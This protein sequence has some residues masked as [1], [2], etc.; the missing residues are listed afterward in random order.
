L[1]SIEDRNNINFSNV[2]ISTPEKYISM[3][4]I[5]PNLD[6]NFSIII[7][8]E[9]HLLD[10]SS[11]GLEY[12]L[13][14]SR[15]LL[16]KNKKRFVFM[17]AIIPNLTEIND[18]LGGS[19]ASII[20]SS[21]RPTKLDFAFLEK[22]DNTQYYKLN[23]NPGKQTSF[24]LN[25][26]LGLHELSLNYNNVKYKI[27]SKKGITAAVALKAVKQGPVLVFTPHKGGK[28]GVEGIVEETIK[29][30]SFLNNNS[31]LDNTDENI[32]IDLINYLNII[33]GDNYLLINAIRN[34]ILYH[35]GD[36]PQFIREII[37]DLINEE[38]FKLII[39]TNTLTEGINL[40]IKT[41][42]VNSTKRY[43]PNIQGNYERLNS[44]ELKN[45]VGRAGRA[46]KETKGLII[47]PHQDDFL[48]IMN[49]MNENDDDRLYGNLYNRIIRPITRILID[50]KIVLD[51]HILALFEE[52]YPDIIDSI[53][54]SL[55]ELLSEEVGSQ[56]LITIV[57]NLITST[58]S[59]YQSDED[60]KDTLTK[61]FIHRATA[62][63]PYINTNAFNEIK[64]SGSSISTYKMIIELF[65]F[66]NELWY[67]TD[68]ALSED[69]LMYLLD[70]GVFNMD[71][72]KQRLE[73][74][75]K[76]NKVNIEHN[77]IKA[78]LIQWM[79][80]AWYYELSI[81]SELSVNVVLDLIN[82]ILQYELQSILSSI[83]R[84]AEI[85]NKDKLISPI[86]L[87]WTKM[88]QYGFNSQLKL[89]ILELG[90]NDRI[91]NIFLENYC[92]S[93]GYSHQS[94]D[95]LRQYLITIIPLIYKTT[96]LQIPNMSYNNLIN[97]LN[98]I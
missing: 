14:L 29:Q 11:R 1:P 68:D 50:K 88:L 15:L 93:R 95:G 24:I 76:K 84:I 9:G 74:F 44:R 22:M 80:G 85:K 10:D 82:T 17:S 5:L 59:F 36:F 28:T 83:I 4:N 20:K 89:D 39:C 69:W 57:T 75:N 90:L 70:D 71:F 26:Y 16:N 66:D 25:K 3:Q 78:L 51:D 38:N 63:I 52:E 81:T 23:F 54:I 92:I 35:H 58:F 18:W 94:K 2:L 12:E 49:V 32:I 65:D 91:A 97:F 43:N 48:S 62:L 53:D 79:K 67:S 87:N 34:G 56:E 7:C 6:D 77:V 40:P 8:D 60:E 96:S 46:G 64:G 41:I 37:E 72:F 30:L 61:I 98:N 31:L 47:V 86:I 19:Q 42:V 21:Y 55:L 33:F 13:L 27:T 73:Y 45:L